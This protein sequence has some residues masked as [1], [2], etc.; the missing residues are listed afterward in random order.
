MNEYITQQGCPNKFCSNYGKH[1][2]ETVVIHD[3]KLNRLRCKLCGK[4]WSAHNKEF[5]Y[6]LRTELLK[7]RRA[8][9]M[10]KA[11]I[12]IRMIARLVK[13]SPSTVMRWKKRSSVA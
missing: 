7:I 2:D 9:E 3:K 5:H 12:P 11:K 1:D 13:V 6:G 4:T 8:I 10:L